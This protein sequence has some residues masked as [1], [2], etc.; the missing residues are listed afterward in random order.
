[1]TMTGR[2]LTLPLTP[3][4]RVGVIIP[5][6]PLTEHEWDRMIELLNVMKPGYVEVAD[7][8]Q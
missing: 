2:L 4:T 3:E 6:K 5:T 1:M 7:H 8:D